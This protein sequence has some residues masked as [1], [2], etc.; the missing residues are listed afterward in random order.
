MNGS[1]HESGILPRTHRNLVLAMERLNEI[2]GTIA[3]LKTLMHR[4]RSLAVPCRLLMGCLLL[5]AKTLIPAG[6]WEAW[7]RARL[8]YDPASCRRLMQTVRGCTPE[9]LARIRQDVA[10]LLADI[11]KRA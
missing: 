1:R 2:A 8:P 6:R 11:L 5:E 10:P 4:Q 3:A 9:G 7:I